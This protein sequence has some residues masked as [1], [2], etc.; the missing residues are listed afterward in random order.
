MGRNLLPVQEKAKIIIYFRNY[1]L[2]IDSEGRYCTVLITAIADNSSVTTHAFLATKPSKYRLTRDVAFNN[3]VSSSV[4]QLAKPVELKPTK[5]LKKSSGRKIH[6]F[7]RD[8]A[9]QETVRRMMMMMM[10]I[11]DRSVLSYV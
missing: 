8:A 7:R 1:L 10:M 2:F 4:Y 11:T 6:G 9:K 5:S 3:S